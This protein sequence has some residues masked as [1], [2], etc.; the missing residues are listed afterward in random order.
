MLVEEEWAQPRA[1]AAPGPGGSECLAQVLALTSPEHHFE[2]CQWG[3][4]SKLHVLSSAT[5]NAKWTHRGLS[6]KEKAS[7]GAMRK[8]STQLRKSGKRLCP[9]APRDHLQ[10]WVQAQDFYFCLDTRQK[11][12]LCASCGM[13]KLENKLHGGF[14]WHSCHGRLCISF[15]SV[16]C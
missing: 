8:R 12:A 7:Q 4:P 15:A 14:G 5:Q 10:N 2:V 9:M 11:I 13:T 1:W 6:A 3:A 16:E